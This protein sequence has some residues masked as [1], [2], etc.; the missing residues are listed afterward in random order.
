MSQSARKDEIAVKVS[1]PI[2]K[3]G[4]FQQDLAPD[5]NVATVLGLAMAHFEVQ[6]DSQFVYVLAHDGEEQNPGTTLGTLAGHA[7]ALHFTLV[8]KIT[9]G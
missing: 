2:T 3:H 5:T 4:P 9:Q 7:E 8:K 1:F 6:N